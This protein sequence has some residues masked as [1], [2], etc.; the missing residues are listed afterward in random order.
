MVFYFGLEFAFWAIDL[1]VALGY[2]T[3]YLVFS[4]RGL[5]EFAEIKQIFNFF[6]HVYTV[7]V[8]GV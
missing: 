5:A 6:R 4:N 3:M 2:L 8:A 1:E 7:G